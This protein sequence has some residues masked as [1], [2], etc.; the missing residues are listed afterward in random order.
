MI[1]QIL[2]TLTFI[3]IFN[4]SY[5]QVRKMEVAD[6]IEIGKISPGGITTM[7]CEKQNDKYI[8]SYKD[9]KFSK[10]NIWKNFTLNS[11]EDFETIYQYVEKG[12]EEMSEKPTILDITDGFLIMQYSKFLGAKVIRFAHA[13]SDSETAIV[14]YSAQYSQRQA[15]KLFN[16]NK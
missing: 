1:K 14:G 7:K 11:S 6:R 16:K 12:F 15:E 13:T 10:L 3:L 9:M 2:L 8:F 4:N 5:S